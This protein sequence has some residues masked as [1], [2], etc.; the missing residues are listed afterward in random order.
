[1]NANYGEMERKLLASFSYDRIKKRAKKIK[2]EKGLKHHEALDEAA[3]ESGFHN[4]REVVNLQKIKSSSYKV[5]SCSY[6]G[7]DGIGADIEIWEP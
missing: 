4:F 5:V 3:K 1:M 7:R 6:P 2:K